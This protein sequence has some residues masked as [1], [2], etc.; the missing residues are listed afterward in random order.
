MWISTWI[1]RLGPLQVISLHCIVFPFRHGAYYISSAPCPRSRV[2]LRDSAPGAGP[3][4]GTADMSPLLSVSVITPMTSALTG[5]KCRHLDDGQTW[6]HVLLIVVLMRKCSSGG[7]TVDQIDNEAGI[8][9]YKF[10]T[11]I[12]L[13]QLTSVFW[14]NVF[15]VTGN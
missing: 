10:F 13:S 9:T 4:C 2:P 14:S 3:A 1:S 11:N 15:T 6:P 12:N 5:G 7:S 8:V